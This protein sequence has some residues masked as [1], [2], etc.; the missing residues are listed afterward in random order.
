MSGITIGIIGIVVFMLLMFLGIPVAASMA[1]CGVVGSYFFLHNWEAC[2]TFFSQGVINTFTS[3]NTAVVPMFML[4]GYH[5][6]FTQLL[7]RLGDSPSNCIS[8]LS[9]YVWMMLSVV[10]AKYNKDA[11]IGIMLSNLVPYF[12]ALQIIWVTFFIIWA[13]AGL[14]IGPGVTMQMPAGILP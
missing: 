12:V 4:M 8:P 6:G 2:Y 14:P 9:A 5:P 10:Q 13:Y 3:Y 7:Y 1:L 11:H